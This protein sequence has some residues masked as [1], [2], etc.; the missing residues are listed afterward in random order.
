MK[1]LRKRTQQ[2]KQEERLNSLDNAMKDLREAL[3]EL[4]QL[5]IIQLALEESKR[6][7]E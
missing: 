7:H 2:L 3:T 1:W 5:R 6:D 4:R